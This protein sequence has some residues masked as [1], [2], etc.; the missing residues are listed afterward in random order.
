MRFLP[1]LVIIL[2]GIL[3][4]GLNGVEKLDFAHDADLYSW[5]V[6]DIVIDHHL[7]LIGQETSTQGI[8]IGPFFYYFLIPFFLITSMDPL[9]VL[10]FLLVLA[11]ITLVSFYFVFT[12][13]FDKFTGIIALVLQAFLPARIG[14]DRWVVPTITSSLWEVWYFYTIVNLLRGNFTVF[15]LLGLL[16]GLIWHI[17]LSLA[18]AL[19]AVPVAI[20]LSKKLITPKQIG[21]LVLGFIIPSVPL[22]VF[23]ARHNF[24]QTRALI[25]SFSADLGGPTGLYKLTQVI[26]HISENVSLMFF[27]PLQ[28]PFASNLIFLIALAVL[29]LLLTGKRVLPGDLLKVMAGW[30]LG[31][32]LYFSLSS[33]IISEY[34]FNNLNIIFFSIVVLAAAYYFKK[35]KR[36]SVILII[37]SLLLLIRAFVFTLQEGENL[38]GYKYRKALAYFVTA[39]SKARGYPCVSVSYITT[40]GENVGFRYFF[41]LNNLHVNQPKSGSP[42]YT[43]VIP[44]SLYGIIPDYTFGRIGLIT[45]K[46]EFKG[47]DVRISCSGQ[48]SNLTDPVFGFTN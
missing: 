14:V 15:P 23:E 44:S 37:I 18:P 45:P 20:V 1:I 17:N 11:G 47:E 19:F 9:G 33:K 32:A 3:L 41:Y 27:H 43:I 26:D 16:I 8:F 42:D 31:V 22:L 40:P 28:P 34:Y 25:N 12:K 36:T 4:R 48:N 13:L 2:I 6:K 39:D 29:G 35:I 30:F 5:I 46:K 24:S 7:R 10:F 21:L 38:A